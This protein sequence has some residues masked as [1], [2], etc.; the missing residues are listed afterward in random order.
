MPPYPGPHDPGSTTPGFGEWPANGDG[1]PRRGEGAN[2]PQFGR[3]GRRG[4]DIVD[5]SAD[6]D[7]E[8]TRRRP[9]WVRV[10][11][12]LI[13]VALL[14]ATLS[15]GAGLLFGASSAPPITT[16][17]VSVRPVLAGPI[18]TGPKEQVNFEVSNS[19]SSESN[20]SCT[21]SVTRLGAV[22][23]KGMVHADRPVPAGSVVT[24]S[25]QVPI[26]R[27]AFAGTPA[28]AMVSCRG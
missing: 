16:A 28:D 2:G 18:A 19:G 3:P 1:R 8:S 20:I 26:D 21:V 22:L 24:A 10:V 17:V 7:E 9:R 13:A 4:D 14:L 27:A 11:G 12:V 25:V 6:G 23:G 5:D 15:T